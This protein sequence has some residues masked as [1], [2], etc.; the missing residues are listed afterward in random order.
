MRSYLTLVALA[1]LLATF[2]CQATALDCCRSTSAASSQQEVVNAWNAHCAEYNF[3]SIEG[4]SVVLLGRLYYGT[5]FKA[6]GD[7]FMRMIQI[8]V[9]SAARPDIED[10][11]TL[12]YVIGHPTWYK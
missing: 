4:T 8:D 11:N 2:G 3:Y 12:D 5:D 9:Q 10:D 1:C 7:A 6:D